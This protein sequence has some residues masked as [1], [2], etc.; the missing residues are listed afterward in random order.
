[1]YE[2][3]FMR[4]YQRSKIVTYII[5]KRNVVAYNHKNVSYFPVC[6]RFPV[7]KFEYY[8]NLGLCFL[9]IILIDNKI[10]LLHIFNSQIY[11]V[12]WRDEYWGFVILY[13]NLMRD[14]LFIPI[15]KY[16]MHV[17]LKYFNWFRKL[18][19]CMK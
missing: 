6:R 19:F 3:S 12:L 11:I 2:G 4:Q 7:R 10:S 16:I 18:T 5:F 17:L 14:D 13:I 15:Q 9:E 1:M 8:K